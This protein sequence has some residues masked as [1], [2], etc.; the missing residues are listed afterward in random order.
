MLVTV[1]NHSVTR[2]KERHLDSIYYMH[3]IYLRNT[4]RLIDLFVY[5]FIYFLFHQGP[6]GALEN[7]NFICAWWILATVTWKCK[8][9]CVMSIRV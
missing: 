9:S 8:H 1:H 5:L 3:H 4:N 2:E 7:S 6:S